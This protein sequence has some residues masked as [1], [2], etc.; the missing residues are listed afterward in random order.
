MP[1]ETMKS[2]GVIRRGVKLT[3]TSGFGMAP[4]HDI[5]ACHWLKQTDRGKLRSPGKCHSQMSIPAYGFETA[6]FPEEKSVR[7]CD[8]LRCHILIAKSGRERDEMLLNVDLA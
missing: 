3:L 4:V 5:R 1:Y 8:W 7:L 2:S 6:A